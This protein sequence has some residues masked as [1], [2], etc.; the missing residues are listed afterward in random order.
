MTK[1]PIPFVQLNVF[2]MPLYDYDMSYA[3]GLRY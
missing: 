3:E 1:P 2:M